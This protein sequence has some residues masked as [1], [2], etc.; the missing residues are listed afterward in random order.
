MTAIIPTAAASLTFSQLIDEVLSN[1]QGYVRDQEKA[2]Y[3]ED[4]V[5]SGDLALT[6]PTGVKS[7]AGILEVDYELMWVQSVDQ[8]SGTMTVAPWG[9]GYGGTAAAAHSANAKITFNPRFPKLR[10][11]KAINDTIASVGQVLPDIGVTTL[12]ADPNTIAYQLPANTEQVL[13]LS[14][15]AP[16]VTGGWVPIRS[17]DVDNN[18]NSTDFASGKSV[19]IFDD[20]QPGQTIQVVYTKPPTLLAN[21]SDVFSST[22]LPDTATDVIVYG[23]MYRL[24]GSADAARIDFKSVAADQLDAPNPFGS[25]TNLSKYFYQL[26]KVRLDEEAQNFW[27]KNQPRLR[28]TR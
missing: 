19:A 22:G 25:A 21:D 1:M 2:T 4:S 3:L 20:V 26:H 24:A 28:W 10:V 15:K 12:T 9:R 13:A 23:A 18:A 14:W 5:T 7:S 11:A 27:N 8:Q 17:Y 6:I 16:G